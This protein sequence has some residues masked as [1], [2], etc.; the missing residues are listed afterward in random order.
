MEKIENKISELNQL[1][2][3]LVHK[4][5]T[6]V[7]PLIRLKEQ[8]DNDPESFSEN[9]S[10]FLKKLELGIN[11]LISWAIDYDEQLENLKILKTGQKKLSSDERDKKR[12]ADSKKLFNQ[13]LKEVHEE[14]KSQKEIVN[15]RIEILTKEEI[16]R[17]INAIRIGI[18][19]NDS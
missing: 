8:R 17:L 1:G 6:L 5:K 15:S 11:K 2:N 12:K 14:R 13:I 9:N 10:D 16:E 18:K 4:L 19:K 7:N 3:E